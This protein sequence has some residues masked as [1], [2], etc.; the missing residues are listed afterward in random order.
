MNWV[1]DVLRDEVS[2][3]MKF[4]QIDIDEIRVRLTHV[5][6]NKVYECDCVTSQPNCQLKQRLGFRSSSASF[7]ATEICVNI[8]NLSMDPFQV[9]LSH[10]AMIDDEGYA[11]QA[12][13]ICDS[14]RS[15]SRSIDINSHHQVLP[16]TQVDV[17]LMF[18]QLDPTTDIAC[19]SYFRK[20]EFYSLRL[21][22][23]CERASDLA[24]AR[25]TVA[26]SQGVSGR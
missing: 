17:S 10:W 6:R 5:H 16:G 24:E 11:Y 14:L 25:T 7:I 15:S 2:A 13:A 20:A 12:L 21:G 19:V 22:Q 23:D 1:S 4:V 9:D 8:R 26:E 18:P 3:Q